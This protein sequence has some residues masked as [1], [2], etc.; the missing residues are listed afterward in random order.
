MLVAICL[1]TPT[2]R[3]LM[4]LTLGIIIVGTR[5]RASDCASAKITAAQGTS[6]E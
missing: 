1:L 3:S 2:K 4:W 5:N 6:Y